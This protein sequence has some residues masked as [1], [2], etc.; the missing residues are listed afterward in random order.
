MDVHEAGAIRQREGQG[1]SQVAGVGYGRPAGQSQS[2]RR[3]H[4]KRG[5]LANTEDSADRQT[6]CKA[7]GWVTRQID[8]PVAEAYGGR[9][10]RAFDKGR[11]PSG[12]KVLRRAQGRTRQIDRPAAGRMAEL[13][14]GSG[15]V[16][17][18]I[19][20]GQPLANLMIVKAQRL[21]YNGQ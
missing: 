2:T 17:P 6:S 16:C 11:I 7:Q 9:Q 1:Q 21:C 14:T 12:H 8:R 4:G 5:C 20:K 13:S 3:N 15:A 18:G 19:C 10:M